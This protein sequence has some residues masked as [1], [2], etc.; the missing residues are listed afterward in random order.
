ERPVIANCSF[1]HPKSDGGLAL[2]HPQRGQNAFMQNFRQLTS[3]ERPGQNSEQR[4]TEVVVLEPIARSVSNLVRIAGIRQKN[5]SSARQAG[6]MCQQ[7][8]CVNGSKRGFQP[9][10]WKILLD[11]PMEVEFAF[12]DQLH[13]NQSQKRF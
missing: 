12:I 10:P 8:M 7:I 4:K 2:V 9:Q 5:G 3:I 1:T 11:W 6:T 13:Q